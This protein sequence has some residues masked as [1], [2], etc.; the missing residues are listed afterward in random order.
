[1]NRRLHIWA[2]NQSSAPQPWLAPSHMLIGHGA[3][4]P[5]KNM[6]EASDET[7]NMLTYSASMNI[8]NFSE[9]YSVWK[10]A[11]SSPS[12]SGKSNGARLVSPTI[13]IRYITND[14]S[15]KNTYQTRSC[16][17][18]ICDVDMVPA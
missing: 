13:E 15:S 14:G 18:T 6:V 1:M 11:T 4:Q 7:V 17:A 12:A 16:A 2:G 5:P 9:E 10:P 3:C 8:A